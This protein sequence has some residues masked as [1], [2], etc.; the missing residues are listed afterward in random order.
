MTKSLG[1][2]ELLLK[3]EIAYLY[4]HFE[5]IVVKLIPEKQKTIAFVKFRGEEEYNLDQSS[6]IVFNA[7]LG[8]EIV[9]KEFYDSF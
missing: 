8:G 2:E 5:D 1:Y 6:K 3:N 7:K 9:T 4:Y